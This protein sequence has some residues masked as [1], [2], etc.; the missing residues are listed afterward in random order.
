MKESFLEHRAMALDLLGELAVV[1]F[2][3]EE[4]TQTAE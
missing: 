2:P 3:A 4:I 1:P